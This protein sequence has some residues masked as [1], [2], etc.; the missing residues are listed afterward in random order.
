MRLTTRERY[1]VRFLMDVAV[2]Q[3]QG[4]VTL[5][6]VARRQAISEKY[7]W[8]VVNLLKKAGLLRAAAGPGGGYRLA[9]P[10]EAITLREIFDGLGSDTAIIACIDDPCVCPFSYAC[11]AR[12]MWIEIDEKIK[13]V[14]ESFTLSD[15]ARRQQV[16]SQNSASSYSI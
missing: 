6:E 16:L 8:Q 4:F 7:L 15:L 13:Q 1:G 11:A 14:L 12:E 2:H 5:K 3:K 10:A 9:K